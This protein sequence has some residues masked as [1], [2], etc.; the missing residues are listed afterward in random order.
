MMDLIDIQR[1]ADMLSEE[2]RAGLAAHLLASIGSAPLGADDDEVDQRD[3]D[4]DS[5][6]VSPIGHAE[7]IRQV[8]RE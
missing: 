5:G 1:E 7:F 2:D 4:M 3:R 6:A 8:G